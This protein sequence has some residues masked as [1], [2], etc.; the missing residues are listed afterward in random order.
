M[1]L[2]NKLSMPR[3]IDGISENIDG[4]AFGFTQVSTLLPQWQ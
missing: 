4:T 3:K 2:K 1:A